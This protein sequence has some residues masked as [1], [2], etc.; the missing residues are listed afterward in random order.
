MIHELVKANALRDKR[1]KIAAY[2]E[3]KP[4]DAN[5]TSAGRAKNRRVEIMMDYSD[6]TKPKAYKA[7][8]IDASL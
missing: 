4:V 8:Q 3:T 5:D 2:A 6:N 1:F 7:P